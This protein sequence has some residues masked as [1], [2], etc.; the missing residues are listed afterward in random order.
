ME[1]EQLRC[2]VAVA[3]ELSFGK[4]A[5]RLE[6]LPAALGRYI[7][8]LEEDVGIRLMIRTT[9][10]VMLT[11]AGAAVLGDA[12]SLLTQ[13]DALAACIRAH[14]R[15]EAATLRVGV[16]NSA[17]GLLPRLI[18]DFKQHYPCVTV[19]LYEAT[20][21]QLLPRLLSGRIDLAFVRPQDIPHKNIEFFPLFHQTAVVAVSKRHHLSEKE[22]LSISDIADEPLIISERQI[23]PHSYNLILQLFTDAGRQ[24][25]MAQFANSIQTIANLVAADL[26][27]AIVPR[28]A[29]RIAASDVRYIPLVSE[30]ICSTKTTLQ[31]VKWLPLAVAWVGDSHDD[32]RDGM[33]KLLRDRIAVYTEDA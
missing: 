10:N 15:N 16:L 27:I 5:R 33:L 6:M 12:K 7:R 32:V 30:N 1:L 14:G 13:A 22:C 2:F 18:H 11:E 28:W 21:R 31:P 29:S 4:A 23:H 3:E 9:R 19:Q 25:R 26:G 20:T 17:M 24:P 8:L